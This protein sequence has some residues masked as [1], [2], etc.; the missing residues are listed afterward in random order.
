MP[1]HTCAVILF[2]G[3]CNMCIG[4]VRF[5]S[6]RDRAGRFRFASLQSEAGRRE[7]LRLGVEAPIDIPDSIVVTAACHA[8]V[9]SDAVIEIARRLPWPWRAA[10]LLRAIPAPIRDSAY[11]WVARRRYRWW[12]KADRC[13]VPRPERH[14]RIPD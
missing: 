7:C 12:G 8:W 10:L 2:D 14:A 5:V 1:M 13:A 4:A 11:R 6:A 3:E 9:R